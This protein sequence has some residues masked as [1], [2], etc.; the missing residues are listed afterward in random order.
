M[1]SRKRLLR[2]SRLYLILDKQAAGKN[3]LSGIIRNF[4]K[5]GIDIVQ[6]RDKT[7]G[8]EMIL[9]EARLLRKLLTDTGILFIVNDHLDIARIV[10]SDGVHLGQEDT[11]IEVARR[12]LGKDKIIGFSCHTLSQALDAQKR[13]AD[14]IGIGPIFSTPTKPEYKPTGLG[15]IGKLKNK[16]KI[17]CFAIGDINKGN[18][19]KVLSSGANRVAVCRAILKA[20]NTSLAA[21]YFSKILSLI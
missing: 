8:K 19:N 13:G 6:F 14:Y 20:K 7:S 2:K 4:R 16:I 9:R 11:S 3:P 1:K 10:D 21:R 17:P 5:C 18:I 15:F 12:I